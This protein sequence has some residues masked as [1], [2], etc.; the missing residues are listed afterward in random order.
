[1]KNFEPFLN[2]LLFKPKGLI[3]AKEIPGK[4]LGSFLFQSSISQ[5]SIR[6][7]NHIHNS[8]LIVLHD[9]LKISELQSG[10]NIQGNR[11]Y[12]FY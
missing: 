4:E 12:V 6:E 5:Q 2:F 10:I 3:G 1:M 7:Y 11:S 9:V 8:R